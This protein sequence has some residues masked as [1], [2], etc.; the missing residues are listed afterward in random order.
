M[1]QLLYCFLLY[2][3]HFFLRFKTVAFSR[4]HICQV[5]LGFEVN[6]TAWHYAAS[7][8]KSEF[9]CCMLKLIFLVED[10]WEELFFGLCCFGKFCG[11]PPITVDII[12]INHKSRLKPPTLVNSGIVN[13]FV[14]RS[15]I[16]SYYSRSGKVDR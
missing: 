10:L 5:N 9:I 13:T 16:W 4:A 11:Q 6:P 2:Y 15:R 14:I 1:N 7:K 8:L 3:H 12:L